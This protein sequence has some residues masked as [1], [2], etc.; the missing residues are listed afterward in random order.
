MSPL[1]LL[2]YEQ[3]QA[4]NDLVVANSFAPAKCK[5]R[6]ASC[7]MRGEVVWQRSW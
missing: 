2:W 6:R 4:L 7:S 5:T 3:L 1:I